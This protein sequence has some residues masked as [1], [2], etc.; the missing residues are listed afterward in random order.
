M[1]TADPFR[2]RPLSDADLARLDPADLL[3][4]E[5]RGLGAALLDNVCLDGPLAGLAREDRLHAHFR[6]LYNLLDDL[7]KLDREPGVRGQ[8]P[9]ASEGNEQQAANDR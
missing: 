5:R 9:V 8:W 3:D 1:T 2:L 4:D 6:P 7:N